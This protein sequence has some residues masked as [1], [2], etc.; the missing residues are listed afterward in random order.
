M[1]AKERVSVKSIFVLA[2]GLCLSAPATAQVVHLN[3]PAHHDS[4]NILFSVNFGASTVSIRFIDRAGIV[5]SSGRENWPASVSDQAI[6]VDHNPTGRTREV[7]TINRLAAMVRW[8][9]YGSGCMGPSF[10]GPCTVETLDRR[11]F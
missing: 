2:F 1:P 9:C 11:K 4:F 8:D 5:T 6:Y 3:C 7:I 10:Y